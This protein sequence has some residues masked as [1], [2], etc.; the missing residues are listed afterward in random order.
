MLVSGG[1]KPSAVV[2]Q[3]DFVRF[4]KK[5]LSS[6]DPS[7]SLEQAVTEECAT[8]ILSELRD[9]DRDQVKRVLSGPPSAASG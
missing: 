4:R 5:G 8:W 9:R 7:G 6:F 1:K 3:G 2:V